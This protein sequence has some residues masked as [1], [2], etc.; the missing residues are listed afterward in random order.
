MNDSIETQAEDSDDILLK[1]L[2]HLKTYERPETARMTRNKQNIMRQVREV[3]S[4][5]HW[6]LSDLLEMN[7]PWLFAEPRYGV[8]LL[9]VAFAMLQFWGVSTQKAQQKEA[10]IYASGN[11]MT[12]LNASADNTATNALNYPELPKHGLQL[13]PNTQ[14]DRS[15]KFAGFMEE[16]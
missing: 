14:G 7:I 13:F 16:K 3:K 12:A 2:L 5:K 6:N 11:S 15:I 9:F 4:R 8:A 10:A 1:Q